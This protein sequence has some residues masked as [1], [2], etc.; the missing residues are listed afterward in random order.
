MINR[1]PTGNRVVDAHLRTFFDDI[2]RFLNRHDAPRKRTTPLSVPQ[3]DPDQF[4]R[5]VTSLKSVWR[6]FLGAGQV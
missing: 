5:G 6:N 1:P 2:E 4:G 3:G